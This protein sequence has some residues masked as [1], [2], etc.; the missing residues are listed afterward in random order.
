M[1]HDELVRAARKA[2]NDKWR[3]RLRADPELYEA[4]LERERERYRERMADP[5]YREKVNARARERY[6]EQT[7]DPEGRARLLEKARRQRERKKEADR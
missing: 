3:A 5:E 4:H 2:S 6:R 1:T 7:A